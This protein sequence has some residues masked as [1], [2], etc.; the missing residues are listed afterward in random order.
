MHKSS[1]CSS[2]SIVAPTFFNYHVFNIN[3]KY[4]NL[5]QKKTEI[6]YDEKCEINCI[7]SSKIHVQLLQALYYVLFERLHFFCFK[8]KTNNYSV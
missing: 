3:Q 2:N 4:K 1:F 6:I 5:Q 8:V 7:T